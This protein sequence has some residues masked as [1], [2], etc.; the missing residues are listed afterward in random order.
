MRVVQPCQAAKA[1]VHGPIFDSMSD[2]KLDLEALD[3]ALF[4]E[5]ANFS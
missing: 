5:E 3:L 1:A 2:G 4:V